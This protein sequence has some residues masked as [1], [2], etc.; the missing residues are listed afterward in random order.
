MKKI[1]FVA[2]MLLTSVATFAQQLPPDQIVGVWKC[3]DFTIEI[4]K[5]ENTY[6]G[7][8]LWSKEMFEADGKTP[9]KDSK[10]PDGKLRNRSVQGITHITGL[11]YKDGEYED[12]ELYSI[13]DG[14]T[15]SFKAVLNDI[16]NL[17]TRGY[18]GV[19]M[20]GKTYKFTR[21]K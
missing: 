2:M 5:S 21:S 15:Y 1:L 12:G 20:F 16:N 7:K 18:K 4:L 19:P 14:N 13:G 6:F 11:T 9:K 3:E 8:L 10:N 17:E